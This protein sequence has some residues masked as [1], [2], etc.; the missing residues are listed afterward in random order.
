MVLTPSLRVALV[1][2]VIPAGPL[3]LLALLVRTLAMPGFLHE[4]VETERVLL[5]CLKL[6]RARPLL[7]LVRTLKAL[8]W[9]EPLRVDKLLQVL[10]GSRKVVPLVLLGAVDGVRRRRRKQGLIIEAVG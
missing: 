9:H 8:V 3:A 10:L 1:I 4:L 6:H 2:I 5:R 7:G